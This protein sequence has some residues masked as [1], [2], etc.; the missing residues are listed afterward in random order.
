MTRPALVEAQRR[1]ADDVK[2]A[3]R[4]TTEEIE[5]WRGLNVP[6]G[7]QVGEEIEDKA[8]SS[9]SESWRTAARF[10]DGGEGTLFRVRLPAGTRAV[11]ENEIEQEVLLRPGSK[12]RVAEIIDRAR[13]GAESDYRGPNRVYVLELVRDGDPR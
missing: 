6:I 11:V 13:D 12:F 8:F 2:A 4:E 1:I 5:V 10:T 9:W 7:K 3:M